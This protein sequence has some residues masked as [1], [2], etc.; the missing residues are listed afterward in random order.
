[1]AFQIV[2]AHFRDVGTIMRGMS[3]GMRLLT[4][5]RISL[6]GLVTHRFRLDAINDAFA[7]AVEKPEGFVKATVTFPGQS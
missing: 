6:D 2:N 5:G 1:M 3:I 7:T 4:A